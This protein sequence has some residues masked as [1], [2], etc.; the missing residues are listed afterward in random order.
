LA[1]FGDLHIH[2]SLS[3]D[4]W[5]FDVRAQPDDA[6]AFG[7]PIQLPIANSRRWTR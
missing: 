1:L 5:N 7:E 6:Y 2:T 3:N 4:A